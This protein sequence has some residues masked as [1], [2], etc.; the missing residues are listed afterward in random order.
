MLSPCVKPTTIAA[1]KFMK[2]P[3]LSEKRDHQG[4]KRLIRLNVVASF[5]SSRHYIR[6]RLWQIDFGRRQA[7][8]VP[9]PLAVQSAQ[10]LEVVR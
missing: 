7:R 6:A 9:Q 2:R 8:G 3:R 1:G 5:V 4:G 10:N